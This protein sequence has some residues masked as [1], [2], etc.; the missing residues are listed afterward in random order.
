MYTSQNDGI[1]D[2]NMLS[3][4]PFCMLKNNSMLIII[5]VSLHG[6][7]TGSLQEVYLEVYLFTGSLPV[8][9]K[10]TCFYTYRKK[11]HMRY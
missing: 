1:K 10:F 2:N 8:Y 5:A 11:P 6:S 9:R 7:Q 3:A 4:L